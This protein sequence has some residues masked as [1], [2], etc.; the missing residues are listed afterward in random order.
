MRNRRK[1]KLP[2]PDTFAHVCQ[3]ALAEAVFV[4]DVHLGGLRVELEERL[5]APYVLVLDRPLK[6]PAT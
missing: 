6:R 1:A 5:D 2:P 4:E 3:R